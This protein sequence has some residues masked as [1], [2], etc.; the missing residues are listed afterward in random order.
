[1]GI[2][3][4]IAFSYYSSTRTTGDSRV[5]SFDMAGIMSELINYDKR[6]DGVSD[7]IAAT[8]AAIL[9]IT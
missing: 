3:Y 1:M 9:E 4:N 8:V 5:F 6:P 7:A 2:L